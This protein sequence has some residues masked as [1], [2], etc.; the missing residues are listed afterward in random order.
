MLEV[1]CTGAAK[2]FV[3][4]RHPVFQ[5]GQPENLFT[6][7]RLICFNIILTGRPGLTRIEV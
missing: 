2:Y 1:S 3:F 5:R 6:N 4:K 7:L